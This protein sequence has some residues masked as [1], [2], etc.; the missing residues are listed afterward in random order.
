MQ[1]A[2][3][4][5]INWRYRPS[6]VDDAL[7]GAL[8]SWAEPEEPGAESL[9]QAMRY[10]LFGGGKRLRSQLVLEAGGV[11]GGPH[12]D[13]AAALPAACAIEMIHAYS[14]VHDDLPSMDN[15]DTRRGRPSCHREFGEA[16]AIL[17]G[18]GL[19]TL[20]FET[21]AGEESAPIDAALRL[22]AVAIIA[23]AAGA[24][25]MV[26]G[27]AIDIDWSDSKINSVSGDSLLAMHAMKTGALIRAACE[28]GAVLG[29]GAAAEVSALVDYGTHLGRAFQIHDD[30][31][32]IV[33]DP[34]MT[35]KGATDVANSKTT[36]PAV[37]GLERAREMADETAAAALAALSGFGAEA[38]ALRHTA[39]FA[40]QRH[41]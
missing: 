23:S 31:L 16:M 33:G 22:R 3:T 36:A 41:K 25:G 2:I 37:F 21:L 28:V 12:W 34:Q 8:R 38:D 18:D 24:A 6:L 14:L 40:V 15:A 27:Q 11:V 19:L 4:N 9:V 1:Q 20:A 13:V 10:A 17:A 5:P 32:D 7:D 30:V 39:Q 35:G 26:G 29:G